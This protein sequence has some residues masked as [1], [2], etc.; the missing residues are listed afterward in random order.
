MLDDGEARACART[1]RVPLI[2]TLGVVLRAQRKGKIA[3]AAPVLSAHR[4][5]G[6][7]LDDAVVREALKS[8]TGED[9]PG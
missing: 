4:A 1:L 3:R 8:S 7:R 9:W 5:A 6:L 2:G